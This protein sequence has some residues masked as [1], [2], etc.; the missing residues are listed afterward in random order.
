MMGGLGG[1]G[2]GFGIILW[3]AVIAL[4][5]WMLVRLFPGIQQQ[6]GAGGSVAGETAEEILRQRFARGEISAQEYEERS[7]TLSRGS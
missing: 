7:R 1:F 4:I 2:M 3:V 6:T 5:V